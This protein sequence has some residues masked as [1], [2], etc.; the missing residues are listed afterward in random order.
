[1]RFIPTRVHGLIDYIWGLLV[2]TAPWIF[3]FADNGPATYVAWIFGVGA[4]LYS[5]GTNYELGLLPVVSM[6]VHLILDVAGGAI[7]AASPWIFGFSDRVFWP[8]LLFGLFSV[9]AGL[10]T[11][12]ETRS[13]DRIASERLTRGAE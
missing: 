13:P 3:G 2:G 5:L 7:L 4:I 9:V 1:M 11:E 12:K 8:H 10:T 6:P